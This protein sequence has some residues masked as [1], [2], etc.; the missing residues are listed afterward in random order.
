MSDKVE[1]PGGWA[2]LRDPEDVTERQRRPL[3]KVRRALL[4]SDVGDVLVERAALGEKADDKEIAKL[5]KPVLNR[6]E[7]DLLSD[8]SDLLIV[9]L[10]EEWSF[11]TPVTVDEVKNLPG[12]AYKA[13]RKAC[14]PLLDAV[15][16]DDGDDEVGDP[17]SNFPATSG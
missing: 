4:A 17:D 7:W 9:A 10:V 14:D 8:S 6:E 5:F 1:F 13:L 2:K 3:A 12:R 11:D 15:L 16:G